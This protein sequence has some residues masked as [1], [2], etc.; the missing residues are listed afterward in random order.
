[1]SVVKPWARALSTATRQFAAASCRSQGI[2]SRSDYAA[3]PPRQHTG[4]YNAYID[5][6]A[7]SDARID[8]AVS[9]R[10]SLLP[11]EVLY[12]QTWKVRGKGGFKIRLSTAFNSKP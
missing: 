8:K 4:V 12:E 11:Y 3:L 5:A 9:E 10:P 2:D 7:Q 6:V 1:L